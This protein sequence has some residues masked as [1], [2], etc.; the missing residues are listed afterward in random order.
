MDINVYIRRFTMFLKNNLRPAYATA[1]AAE[2]RANNRKSAYDH[3]M[4]S[5]ADETSSFGTFNTAPKSSA[6]KKNGGSFNWKPI[7][8]AAAAL[9]LLVLLVVIVVACSAGS[10]KGIKYENNAFLAFADDND[11][12][13]VAVNG[14]IIAEYEGEI[15]LIPADDRSFAYVIETTEDGQR[16][17]VVN[18][19]EQKELTSAPVTK[20]LVTASL[21]PAAVWVDADNEGIWMYTEKHGLERIIK[22]TDMTYAMED[23]HDFAIS[24]DGT[25]VVYIKKVESN[26]GTSYIDRLYMYK[27]HAETGL[28]KGRPSPE[29]VSDDGSLVY[30]SA[31]KDET[32]PNSLYV[33][34]LNEDDYTSSY[35]IA[36]N[37]GRIVAMNT[38]GTEV[39]FT[40][41]DSDTVSTYVVAI[42]PRKLDA[43]ITP[44]KIPG[45]GA[46]YYPV[47]PAGEISRFE[48]FKKCYF[49]CDVKIDFSE[50]LTGGDV[51]TAP[52][53]YLNK[54]Y[55]PDQI[56]KYAGK[57]DA[58]GKHFFYI[59]KSQK[60][61]YIDLTNSEATPVSLPSAEDIIDFAV[62]KKGNVYWLDTDGKLMYYDV[63]KDQNTRITD[64]AESIS[65]HSYANKLYF[66]VS[67][68]DGIFES[69]EGSKMEKATMG[70][71]AVTG[72]PVFSDANSKNTY[73]GFYDIE[74]EE[75][76][77]AY[78]SNGKSFKAIGTC[79]DIDGMT[80][81]FGLSDF[82]DMITPPDNDE[83]N[84]GNTEGNG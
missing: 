57:F 66:S 27:D 35:H 4:R 38:K 51:L 43:E 1:N 17:Y 77:L 33:I 3:I 69:K 80:P 60:L 61:K 31:R 36:E 26:D 55:E 28:V 75:W 25:T 45:K 37:F 64:V 68:S 29:A 63:D 6:S 70:K 32:K 59:D 67:E 40:T 52:V 74:N 42:N 30:V 5:E 84:E 76:S 24:A 53:Y 13:R 23:D 79:T 54:K 83:N 34:P 15:E 16:L 9:L 46:V 20:I 58:D 82:I 14:K 2:H 49:Q 11:V 62:T 78:T 39:V 8:I 18:K 44:V 10:S 22:N 47:D 81:I 41:L 50:I 71:L 21:K 7:I 12:Y 56:S 73:V 72:I 65:M 19:K 48:T